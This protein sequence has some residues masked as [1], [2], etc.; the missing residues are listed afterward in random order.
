MKIRARALFFIGLVA[1]VI[2]FIA[3]L[4]LT[5][6]LA[7]LEPKGTIADRQKELLVFATLLSL[8][9]IVPVYLLAIFIGVRYRESNKKAK[10]TPDHDHSKTLETFWWGIPIT[11]IFILSVITWNTS[12]SLDP[13]KPLAAAKSTKTIQVVALQ[14]KWLFIYPE[15]NIASVNYLRI[16]E[17]TPVKFQITADAPM[18]SFWIPQ[19]GGQ[20]Y[21]MPG[22][23]TELHLMAENSG[24]YDGYSANISGEGFAH[25]RFIAESTSQT[26]YEKWVEDAKS[27]P[28][29]LSMAT[30]GTLKQPGI[31][32]EIKAYA[33]VN[34]GLFSSI[35]NSYMTHTSNSQDKPSS[36][37]HNDQHG[38][39]H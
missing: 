38:G 16:P 37:Q 18:N 36:E 2:S 7:L 19:L 27:Q 13:F 10:Y 30:Y 34:T 33:D 29:S 11:I 15:E 32:E 28:A 23:A 9:V 35:I 31:E 4:F 25:M 39:N 12:H 14:W 3:Y 22:M 1:A 21:A 24:T 6:D 20:I 8:V 26:D 5:S 17:D